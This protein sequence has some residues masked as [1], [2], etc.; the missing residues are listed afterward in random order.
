M[1]VIEIDPV[2]AC[3]AQVCTK[4]FNIVEPNVA[5]FGRKDYQQWRIIC[6][7]VGA[8]P[9]F[10]PCLAMIA[11]SLRICRLPSFNDL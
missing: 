1:N 4:L 10:S 2:L 11:V 9:S 5:V 6:R 7:L 3:V 8:W